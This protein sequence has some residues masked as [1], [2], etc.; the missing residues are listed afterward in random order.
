[1]NFEERLAQTQAK[2]EELK[3]K[4]NISIDSAKETYQA[5]KKEAMIQ[6]AKMNAEQK[7]EY[8]KQKQLDEWLAAQN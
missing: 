6:L 8:E 5:D 4:I 7:A 3:T 1:M 2:L